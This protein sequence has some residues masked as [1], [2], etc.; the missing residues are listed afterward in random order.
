MDIWR[1]M[2]HR[3]NQRQI[4]PRVNLLKAE[5]S[6]LKQT[7]WLMP[8][9]TDLN[10]WRTKIDEIG[11]SITKENEFIDL[12]FVA[13][14]PGLH[15]ENYVA[16]RLNATI[17][18]LN[19]QVNVET[20]KDTNY[21]LNV[22]DKLQLPPG[23]YHKVYTISDQPSCYLYMFLNETAKMQ[24]ALFVNYLKNM[25]PY[26]ERNLELLQQNS[27]KSGEETSLGNVTYQAY[28]L[29][30]ANHDDQ[31]FLS[32]LTMSR[33]TDSEITT[34]ESIPEIVEQL[35]NFNLTVKKVKGIFM[36]TFYEHVQKKFFLRKLPFYTKVVQKFYSFYFTY[37]RSLAMVYYAG[38]SIFFK[39]D[40]IKIL[41][42]EYYSDQ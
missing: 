34:Y 21:T 24:S 6:P 31:A 8:L 40:F 10:D 2:N 13:D 36:R 25:L 1:S 35:E 5:W 23:N 42:K 18:V 11:D 39:E 19:G 4:D 9:L 38:K 32:N 22:G 16:K 27:A 14:F 12:T 41:E 17:E 26:Y 37:K 3:F 30:V 15:L 33:T 7:S 29:T 28:K 20:D